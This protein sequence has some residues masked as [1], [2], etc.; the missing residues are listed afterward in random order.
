MSEF[1]DSYHLLTTDSRDVIRLIRRSGRYG[2]ILPS[3]GRFIPFVVEG[4]DEA[5]SP[6]DAVVERNEKLLVHYSFSDGRGLVMPATYG[7]TSDSG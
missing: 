2:L 7:A 4:V 5:G 1:S 6:M 3:S